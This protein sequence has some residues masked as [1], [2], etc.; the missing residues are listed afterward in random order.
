MANILMDYR[1]IAAQLAATAAGPG[2]LD[3]FS[4]ISICSDGELEKYCAVES[5]QDRSS[6][7]PRNARGRGSGQRVKCS[8][9]TESLKESGNVGE[10]DDVI[11]LEGNASNSSV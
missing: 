7:G 6:R 11:Q 5:E 2:S 3:A 8:N 10:R 9:G 1:P 4:I